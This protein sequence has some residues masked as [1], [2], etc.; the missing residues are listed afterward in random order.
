LVYDPFVSFN[1]LK[2]KSTLRYKELLS[3]VCFRVNFAGKSGFTERQKGN[4][5]E[6][7]KRKEWQSGGWC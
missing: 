3:P 4:R 5:K 1:F 2:K 7:E 6:I